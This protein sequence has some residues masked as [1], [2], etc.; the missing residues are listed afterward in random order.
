MD[1]EHEEELQHLKQL[2]KKVFIIFVCYEDGFTCLSWQEL[3]KLLDDN[4][5]DC[6]DENCADY[7]LDL[8]ELKSQIDGAGVTSLMDLHLNIRKILE[9]THYESFQSEDIRQLYLQLL[10]EAF[11]WFD[12]SNPSRFWSEWEPSSQ[13]DGKIQS[14]ERQVSRDYLVQ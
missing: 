2:H 14:V 4:L 7:A 10:G 6:L 3:K 13:A 12:A 8:N 5:E 9:D 1:L 11:P